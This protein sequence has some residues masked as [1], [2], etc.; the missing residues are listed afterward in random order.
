VI[1]RRIKRFPVLLFHKRTGNDT[2][3][4][5]ASSLQFKKKIKL[6]FEASPLLSK[7]EGNSRGEV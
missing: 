3:Q 4:L 6:Q 1:K 5:P 7:G 2:K